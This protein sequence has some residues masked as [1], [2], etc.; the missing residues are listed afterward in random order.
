MRSMLAHDGIRLAYLDEGTGAPFVFQHGLGGDATQV[1][2]M[3]SGRGRL[4][5]LD[6]RGH[7]HTSAL[8]DPG[9]LGFANFARDLAALLDALG[10]ERVA[11]GGISMGAGVA[12]RLAYEEPE[13]V[14]R[15]VL[16]RPAWFTR[17]DPPHLELHATVG[18]LLAEWPLPQARAALEALPSYAALRKRSPSAAASLVGQLTRPNAV[19]RAAVLRKMPADTPL[20]TSPPW[21]QLTMPALVL[22]SSDDPAHPLA[23]AHAW[24]AALANA[25]VRTVTPKAVDE[26]RH[27]TEVAAAIDAFLAGDESTIG[28]QP[29]A[30]AL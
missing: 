1:R 6:C 8:G 17:P 14:S 11:V 22:G 27:V 9:A 24:A 28:D 10:L 30:R 21:S 16:V 25:T 13:R 15:L 29:R 19:E 20:P 2:P 26:E 23:Y 7:G 5:S 3:W 4:I 18:R 12:V